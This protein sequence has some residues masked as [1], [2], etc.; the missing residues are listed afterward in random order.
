MKK[1]LIRH[2]NKKILSKKPS[3]YVEHFEK[4]RKRRFY[5]FDRTKSKFEDWMRNKTFDSI[6]EEYHEEKQRLSKEHLKIDPKAQTKEF[7][8]PED[9]DL[10]NPKTW[11]K[12]IYVPFVEDK[13]VKF[14]LKRVKTVVVSVNKKR[15]SHMDRLQDVHTKMA[16]RFKSLF[17]YWDC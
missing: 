15:Q 11:N 7:E 17:R 1:L 12:R 3:H 5:D 9:V 13:M 10:S 8:E 16:Q 6:L 14:Y 4:V 2:V